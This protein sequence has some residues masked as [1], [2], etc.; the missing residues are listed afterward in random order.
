MKA[1]SA[2]FIAFRM[3]VQN[4]EIEVT[5]ETAQTIETVQTEDLKKYVSL[6]Q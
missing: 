5:E 3:Y 1:Q 6:T 4:K 2:D